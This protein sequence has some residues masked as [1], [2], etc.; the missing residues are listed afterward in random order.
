MFWHF[1]ENPRPGEVYNAGGGR[2]SNCSIQE[3]IVAAE[4]LVGKKMNVTYS[5]E[6][7]IGDH[8][9]FISDVRKFQSHYPGWSYAY[10]LRRI[11]EE[12]CNSLSARIART[13][14]V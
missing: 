11:L 7:R 13:S 6:N 2:H 14:A 1:Y 3:A 9:W 4:Q 8:I 12:N 10:D 5:D